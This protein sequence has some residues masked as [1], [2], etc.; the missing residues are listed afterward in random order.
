MTRQQGR[1]IESPLPETLSVQGDRNKQPAFSAF[2]PHH[3]CHDAGQKGRDIQPI[4]IFALKDQPARR[5]VVKISGACCRP[6]V[7][8]NGALGTA[9]I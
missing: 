2:I 8:S 7:W 6:G 4:P 3:V 5:A 9:A 1:L